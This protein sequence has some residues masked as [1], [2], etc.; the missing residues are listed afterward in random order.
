MIFDKTRLL[1]LK[2]SEV[3]IFRPYMTTSASR[4]HLHLFSW[5]QYFLKRNFS[6]YPNVS[7]PQN[8]G[9]ALAYLHYNLTRFWLVS[10]CDI[11]HIIIICTRMYVGVLKEK[12]INV[13]NEERKIL[14][15][16]INS[17]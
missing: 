12:K 15:L 7:T 1:I 17:K 10:G 2:A 6:I 3:L 13:C 4:L 16:L 11:V 9:F 14:L 5:M 8:T